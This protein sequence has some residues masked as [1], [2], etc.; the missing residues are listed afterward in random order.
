M[1]E[2]ALAVVTA[3]PFLLGAAA[4]PAAPEGV[5][6]FAFTDERIVES[7]GLVVV[8]GLFVTVNDSGDGARVFSV[9]P[10]TGDTVGT[11]TWDGE[12]ADVEALAPAPGGEV[13][14]GDIGDNRAARESIEVVR[15]PVGRGDRHVDPASYEL[16]YPDGAQDAE[17]L[18]VDPTGRLVVVSK[19][20]F[21]ATVYAAPRRVRADQPNRLRALGPAPSV[22]TDAAFLPGGRHLVVRDYGDA[23]VLSWPT[24]EPVAEVELPEQQQGEAV[25]VDGTGRWFVST[26]GQ[27]SPVLRVRLPKRVRVALAPPAATPSPTPS[28]TPVEPAPA[29]PAGTTERSAADAARD[30]ADQRWRWIW[31]AAT[32]ALGAA[33]LA[34]L[35]R[36]R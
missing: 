25:A 10:A 30:E 4:A 32:A 26:E 19:A 6:V 22:A 18:A 33:V 34:R 31:V 29:P 7:S 9:D 5:E 20:F 13:W 11:T 27:F 2:R 8:D 17:G 16:V 21:G 3:A 14:V 12:P 28:P 15:V 36:R 23:T 35:R 1:I 24:L